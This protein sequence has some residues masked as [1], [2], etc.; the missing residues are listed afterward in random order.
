M[1]RSPGRIHFPA[2]PRHGSRFVAARHL[3]TEGDPMA[4]PFKPAA[5]PI[6]KPAVAA[7]A[8]K[9]IA[10]AAAAS[11]SDMRNSPVP[12]PAS[13][14]SKKTE[15]THDAIARRAYEIWQSGAGGSEY[16]NWIRAERELRGTL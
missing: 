2:H 6:A 7:P 8:A 1:Q 11:R 3:K 4:K 16:D 10:P 15:V 5:K 13:P 12:R 14:L 9:S